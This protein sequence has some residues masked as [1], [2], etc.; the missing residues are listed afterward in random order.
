MKLNCLT[1]RKPGSRLF[2]RLLTL[3]ASYSAMFCPLVPKVLEEGKHPNTRC[4]LV[5]LVH[6]FI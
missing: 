5:S 6:G 1:L 3:L 2:C 4:D